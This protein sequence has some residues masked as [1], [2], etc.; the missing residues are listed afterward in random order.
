MRILE[1]ALSDESAKPPEE[2]FILCLFSLLQAGKS[3]PII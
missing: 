3:Y 2:N 1:N